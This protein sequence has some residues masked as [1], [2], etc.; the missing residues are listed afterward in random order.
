MIRNVID[1]K[2]ILL[3]PTL[4]EWRNS[5]VAF[6]KRDMWLDRAAEKAGDNELK[7]TLVKLRSLD[8]RKQ[9]NEYEEAVTFAMSKFFKTF[10]ATAVPSSTKD[11]MPDI[12]FSKAVLSNAISSPSSRN[13]LGDNVALATYDSPFLAYNNMI[14]GMYDQITP[15]NASP[16]MNEF[17]ESLYPAIG[18][19]IA[20]WEQIAGM[21]MSRQIGQPF[22][23]VEK[24]KVNYQFFKT[25]PYG[26]KNVWHQEEAIGLRNPESNNFMDRDLPLFMAKNQSKIEH[27]R[28][29]RVLFDIYRAIYDG[30]YYF[31]GNALSYDID[32]VNRITGSQL[33]G[34]PWASYNPATDV[35]TSFGNINVTQALRNFAHAILRKYTGY[36]LNF[37]LSSLTLSAIL[38]SDSIT[39][40]T[41][42]G[43]GF[44]VGSGREGTQGSKQLETILRQFLG[45]NVNI[46][47]IIDDSQYIA[48]ET[49]PLGRTPGQDY[50]LN[51]TGKIFVAPQVQ[52]TGAGMG[53]YAYTPI[54]QKG[55]MYNPQPGYAFFIIDTFASNTTEGMEN[56]SLAQALSFSAI[57]LIFRNHDLFT[58]DITQ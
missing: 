48:D 47:I 40:I 18:L 20:S 51:D 8:I 38:G 50:Y 16:I 33:A 21:T 26:E 30:V 32:P 17:P 22:Y 2:D 43:P 12:K 15:T 19:Y 35:I 4:E 5:K 25:A 3:N 54:V 49:D 36:D 41:T 7:D 10:N 42:F 11:H 44:Q 46:N 52:A 57:P 29:T 34:A 9:T 6:N 13:P 53:Q 23:E 27:R 28:Q 1:K 58:L 39:P 31:N 37:Y 24:R 55:G 14:I 56:P 45:T